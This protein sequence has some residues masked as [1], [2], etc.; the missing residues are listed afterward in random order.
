MKRRLLSFI[1]SVLVHLVLII[2]VLIFHTGDSTESHYIHIDLIKDSPSESLPED[3]K[4][5]S[6]E[7]QTK[8]VEISQP[9]DEIEPLTESILSTENFI[10]LLDSLYNRARLTSDTLS[11]FN[12]E[13]WKTFVLNKVKEQWFISIVPDSFL[14]DR[15]VPLFTFDD[16]ESPIPPR[17]NI[18]DQIFRR[19]TGTTPLPLSSLLALLVNSI[20]SITEK[21]ITPQFDFIPNMAQIRAM[22]ILYEKG[23]ATQLDIYPL[24]DTS[25]PITAEGFDKHLETLVK[26]G[27]LTKKKIS[28]EL[29][30]SLFGLPI[31][32]SA[33][34][35]KNPLYQYEPKVEK[36]K[37]IDFLQAQLYLY[38]ERH[39]A[40]PAD[41]LSLIPKIKNLQQKI[42]ILTQN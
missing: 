26:K 11:V 38:Q 1:L 12:Q 28:P 41:S 9:Q 15:K 6:Q 2:L 10:A 24:L 27:F 19:N 31:E 34:N 23:K 37:I 33:K 35:R 32:M 30:F 29:S 20:Q 22:T 39:R 7:K 4:K 36:T 14:D 42:H 16:L 18:K 13:A 17:D 3:I 5:P 40:M 8:T 25:Q 21:K